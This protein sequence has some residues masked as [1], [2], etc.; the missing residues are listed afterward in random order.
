MLPPL[1]LLRGIP[2]SGK[3][4][5]AWKLAG[6][7]PTNTVVCEADMFFEGS[8]G[9]QYNKDLIEAAHAQC[10]GA[11]IHNLWH[12]QRVIVS[13]TNLTDWEVKKYLKFAK[14]LGHASKI[15]HCQGGFQSVHNVPEETLTAMKARMWTNEQLKEVLDPIYPN[16]TY[17][18]YD[19]SQVSG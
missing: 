8:R 5:L 16:V 6:Q 11:A 18:V 15:I 3:S 1:T 13:N 9:Y 19:G 4:T 14:I 12:G 17:E 7:N 10:F 2:G